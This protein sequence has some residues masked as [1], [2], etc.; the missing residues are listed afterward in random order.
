MYN[1]SCYF[2]LCAGSPFPCRVI[3]SDLITVT[4]DGLKMV[5]ANML[6]SFKVDPHGVGEGE[7]AIKVLCEYCRTLHCNTLSSV[8]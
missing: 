5:P 1:A 8:L 2:L 3:D 7:L 6:A 4:G